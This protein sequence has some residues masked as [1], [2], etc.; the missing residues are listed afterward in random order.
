[1]RRKYDV[2]K[3]T[4]YLHENFGI[5][6]QLV[7]IKSFANFYANEYANYVTS[8][9]TSCINYAKDEKRG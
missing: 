2:K 4:R 6:E 5:A 3:R 9:V 7:P 1:M 8:C